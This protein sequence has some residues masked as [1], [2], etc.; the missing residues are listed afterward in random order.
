MRSG[1]AKRGGQ[2]LQSP[3]FF[4]TCGSMSFLKILVNLFLSSAC[5]RNI[6]RLCTS[7]NVQFVG[8]L[9]YLGLYGPKPSQSHQSWAGFPYNTKSCFWYLWIVLLYFGKMNKILIKFETRFM[10][11]RNKS[12]GYCP[13]FFLFARLV[14][15]RI[16][17]IWPELLLQLLSNV[18][19]FRAFNV[20]K[21]LIASVSFRTPLYI[22]DAKL[23]KTENAIL[24]SILVAYIWND[25][26]LNL[27]VSRGNLQTINK[28]LYNLYQ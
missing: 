5:W 16:E 10:L 25:N 1:A 22:L 20:L 23:R 8:Y 11:T 24:F 17:V 15:H 28:P 14:L 13:I 19:S 21:L 2:W 9:W 6:R 26:V 4:I 27:R 3:R 18:R 7:R 12:G